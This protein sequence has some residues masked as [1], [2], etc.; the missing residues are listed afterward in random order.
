MATGTFSR[1]MLSV[2]RSLRS[3]RTA[4]ILLLLLGL[5]SV[6]GSLVPQAPN[7]PARVAELFAD[8]PLLARIYDA[9]GFFDVFGSWWF[10]LLYVLLL[11][12]LAAC[13][14][15]R[16]RGLIRGLGSRW[17][18][19]RDLEA[20]RHYASGSVDGSPEE[21]V[22]RAR[23]AL[24]RRGWGVRSGGETALAAE[25]GL[26]RE[27]GS[28]AFHWAF[29]LLLIGVVYGKGFGFTGQATVI[30]GDVFTEAHASYDF[31]PR[32]GRFFGERHQGFQVR[33]LDFEV[34]YR[35][36]GV[37]RDFVSRVDVVE[38]GEVVRTDEIRVNDPLEHRGVKLYQSGYGW[39]PV[40][41]VRHEGELLVSD[42][43]VF[44]TDDP[45]DP[46][47]PW[48]G[49]IKLPALSPQVGLELQLLPD[50]AAFV[51][52]MPMLE[53]D[54]PFIAY[55]AYRGD[56]R[57]TEAQSV[58]RL[59][60]ELL[61][62][63]DSGGLALG[64]TVEL[65]GGLEVTFRDLRRYTQLLVKRDPGIGLMLATALLVLVG[66]V[67]A[68]YSSR[69]RIWVRAVPEDGGTRLEIGGFAL[70]RKA[71]F[72]EEFDRLVRDLVPRGRV[73]VP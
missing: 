25:K 73:G 37:P 33:V 17:Q 3:M 58:F 7:S 28:L 47:R 8:R 11:I 22:G 41:E 6:V 60:K 54:D 42:P 59:E 45:N 46:V 50:A 12:S 68:L 23:R 43:L 15:P 9:L 52:G 10:T 30:E 67:P 32:E 5:G 36:G 29:F 64:E 19:A 39:A 72:D 16:T 35:E 65:P 20:L 56:L 44:V 57:L 26:A 21:A 40:V 24:R 66:L 62:E 13:L 27:V 31:P 69:R 1:G 49:A 18:P 48:R 34:T 71:A 38:E 4:L 55:R 14:I 61:E 63:Y 70:Q 51:T 53:A 2:W